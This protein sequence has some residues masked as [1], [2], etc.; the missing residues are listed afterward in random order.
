M[1]LIMCFII[2]ISLSMDTFS[3]SIIYGTLGMNKKEILSLSTLVGIF[4][5]FMPLLGNCIGELIL[6][7]LPIESS[8]FAGIIFFVIAFQM[9]V[10][11]FKNEE[12]KRITSFSS[13]LLFAFTVSID[14]FSVGIGLNAI[15][16]NHFLATTIFMIVSFTFTFL[17]LYMGKKLKNY[18]GK[19]A[20]LLGSVILFILSI[21]YI[22]FL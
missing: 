12:V 16:L 8:T 20:T 10:S 21:Y 6:K 17:G 15:L 9:V 3:L 11:L 2:A 7:H 14:S 5:F 22:L 18:F 19:I 13:F 4:H 1:S